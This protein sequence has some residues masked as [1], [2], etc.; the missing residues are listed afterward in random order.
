MLTLD[1]ASF[2]KKYNWSEPALLRSYLKFVAIEVGL[3][4]LTQ[5]RSPKELVL[6]YED[7]FLRNLRD[8]DPA[9]GGDPSINIVVAINEPNSTEEQAKRYPISMHTGKDNYNNTR[10]Y[11]AING[12]PYTNVNYSYWNGDNVVGDIKSPWT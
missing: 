10:Y 7:D 1:D 6:G 2:A 8:M 12:V 4:G 9:M 3:G 5:E 11:K